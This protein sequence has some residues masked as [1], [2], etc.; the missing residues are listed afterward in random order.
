MLGLVLAL[1][2]LLFDSR[3]VGRLGTTLYFFHGYLRYLTNFLAFGHAHRGETWN[4][5]NQIAFVSQRHLAFATGI[6]LIVLIFLVDRSRQRRSA[7]PTSAKSFVFSGLLLVALPLWN[8]SVFIAIAVMLCCLFLA[9]CCWRLY[10]LKAPV[11]LGPIL[12]GTLTTCILAA[13]VM[14][15][16][17][18]YSGSRTELKYA[19][20]PLVKR[21]IFRKSVIYEV[22]DSLPPRIAREGSL[23]PNNTAIDDGYGIGKGKSKNPRGIASD[24]AGNIFVADT[25]NGRIEKFSPEGTLLMAMGIK[26]SVGGEVAEPS[27]IAVARNGNIYIADTGTHRVLK[28]KLD[29]TL[30]AEWKAPAPGFYGPRRIAIGP[31]DSVYVV[32]QG[33]GRIIKF[34][35]DGKV[36]ASWGGVGSDDGQFKEPAA[37]AVDPGSNKIYVADPMNSRIQVFDSDGKFLTKWSVPE[38]GQ[39]FGFED[40]AVD[41][42]KNLLYASSAH[43]DSVL[44]FDFNG[45]RVGNLTPQP[46]NKLAD[47]S[48]IAVFGTKLYVLSYRDGRIVQ[49]VL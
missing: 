35:P 7:A 48:G 4:F 24:S 27:G 3:V 21:L 2:E 17:P 44:A 23:R 25:G 30:S 8:L 10:R 29:G 13:G 45:T 9:Y 40:L 12:G 46:P 1:G 33:H 28:V 36:L 14:D 20:E 15:L 6:F 11:M 41:S 32:D 47:P 31:D 19:S 34:D 38:W 49:I 16:L 18:V 22:P 43:T 26:G 42:N 5:W 39:P 37:V